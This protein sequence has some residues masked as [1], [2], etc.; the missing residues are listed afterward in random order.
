MLF[1]SGLVFEDGEKSALCPANIRAQ[2]GL[3]S[4][5]SFCF[6]HSVLSIFASPS[7]WFG[8]RLLL[9]SSSV[10]IFHETTKFLTKC[11]ALFYIIFKPP[12]PLPSHPALVP[13]YP[14]HRC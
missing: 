11:K 8:Y 5:K 6:V 14:P 7:G 12:S 3:E 10:S 9:P 1:V 13:V 4:P 2:L